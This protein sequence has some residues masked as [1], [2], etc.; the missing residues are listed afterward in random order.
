MFG[1]NIRA[2]VPQIAMSA[3]TMLAC[4]C[5]SIVMGKQSNLGPIDPHLRDIP[6]YGVI[7]EFRRAYREVK[8]DPSKLAI[9]QFII[10]QYRPTFLGQ[11]ENA[12]KW[13]NDFVRDQ[14]EHVMFGNQKNARSRAKRIVKALSDYRKNK[15]H[16]RHIHMEECEEM[17]LEVERL[18]DPQCTDLQDLVL[19]V[20]HCFMH[21]L[22]NTSAFKIIENHLGSALVKREGAFI[23]QQQPVDLPRLMP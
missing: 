20:H 15:V 12:V 8:K 16:D 7:H 6:T 10:G 17:G 4:S 13:S 9:W 1:D 22:M 3:G 21:T 19:T 14:L 2:I 11:C 23:L 5:R 18:E